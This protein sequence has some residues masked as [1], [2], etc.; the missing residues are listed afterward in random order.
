MAKKINYKQAIWE[1]CKEPAR[2]LV[3]AILPIA[4]AY[5]SEMSYQWAAII[6]VVLRLIDKLMHEIGKVKKQPALISGLTKF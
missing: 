4:I 6:T 3:L 1:A 2:L 5:F